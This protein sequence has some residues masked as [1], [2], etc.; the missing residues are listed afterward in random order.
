VTEVPL[1][2]PTALNEILGGRFPIFWA[3][4]GT[5]DS[6]FDIVQSLEPGSIW[7]PFGSSDP[8]LQPLLDQAQVAQGDEAVQAFQDINS[9]VVEDAWFAPWVAANSFFATSGPE[10][11]PEMTDQFFTAANLWDFR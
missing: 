11:V 10:L 4:I 1:T 6:M 8:A 9:K 2:G 7:N 5:A 3:R